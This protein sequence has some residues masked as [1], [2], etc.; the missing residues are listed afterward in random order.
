MHSKL[1]KYT[2][3]EIVESRGAVALKFFLR[4]V[5]YF[6]RN[7]GLRKISAL[8]PGSKSLYYFIKS[9]VDES[10]S[11]LENSVGASV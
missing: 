3:A 10:N 5:F 2:L 6:K 9:F 4:H 7:S 11:T 1:F 8:N